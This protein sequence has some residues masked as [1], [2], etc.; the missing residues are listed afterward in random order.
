MNYGKKSWL[1]LFASH[2]LVHNKRRIQKIAVSKKGDRAFAVVDV[3]DTLWTRLEDGKD[4][5]WEGR[6][7]KIYTKVV[8]GVWKIIGHRHTDTGLLLHY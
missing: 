7:C 1:D 4:F 3:I 2:R 5:H 6:A 8:N